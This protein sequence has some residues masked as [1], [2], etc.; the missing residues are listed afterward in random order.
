[1]S[2]ITDATYQALGILAQQSWHTVQARFPM[3]IVNQVSLSSRS[4]CDSQTLESG[5]T[6]GIP[7][8]ICSM[9]L[10]NE[11]Q[12]DDKWLVANE[13]DSGA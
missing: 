11:A 6:S 9:V 13:R 2:C 5:H 10:L 12:K 3:H 4:F 8:N 7:P 1:M